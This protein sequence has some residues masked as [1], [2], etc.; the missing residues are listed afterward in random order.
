MSK[1]LENLRK[2]GA[3]RCLT[4]KHGAQTFAQKPM[5]TFCWRSHQKRVLYKG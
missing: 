2:N 4:S 5:K 3:Q 1:I